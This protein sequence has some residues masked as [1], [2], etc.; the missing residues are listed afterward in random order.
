MLVRVPIIEVV[1]EGSEDMT[2]P[3]RLQ[4]TVN[5]SS[6]RRTLQVTWTKSPSFDISL[7]KVNGTIL[8]GSEITKKLLKIAPSIVSSACFHLS[9]NR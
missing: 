1:I 8:G 9:S 6:P 5:G 4:E 2:S 3:L 7:P